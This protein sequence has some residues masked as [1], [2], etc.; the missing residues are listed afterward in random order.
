MAA[1]A[2]PTLSEVRAFTGEYLIDAARHWSISAY[3]WTDA[4]DGVARGA[5][6]P[7]GTEWEGDA[8]EA[9]AL[10]VGMDRRRVSGAADELTAVASTARRAV[11]DLRT[12]KAKLLRT[13]RA[14][15]SAGFEIGDDFSLQTIESTTSAGELAARETQMRSFGLAIRSNVLALVNVDELAAAQIVEAA[16]RLRSLTF[17]GAD[18]GASDHGAIQA[19]DFHGVPLPEKPA[20]PPPIPPPEGWSTDTVRRAAQ[21]IAYGHAWD[22][23]RADF[24]GIENQAQ[25][26][27]FIYQ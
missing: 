2:L 7:A 26:A 16:T 21:K 17:V 1:G 11:D 23:H 6:R 18:R 10:R 8:A 5:A 19:I 22:R 4:Y 12:V 25:F 9:A 14:A 27:E 13:V 20:Y 24:P 15:E 3:Q